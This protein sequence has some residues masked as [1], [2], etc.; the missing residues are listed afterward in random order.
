MLVL[1]ACL[2]TPESLPAVVPPGLPP[3]RS[4]DVRKKV[5]DRR[6]AAVAGG[7]RGAKTKKRVRFC[8][9]DL[10]TIDMPTDGLEDSDVAGERWV[11][12]VPGPAS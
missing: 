6:T 2:H 5:V 11:V 7:D 1:P 3:N 10:S 9:F 4:L 8:A 12:E